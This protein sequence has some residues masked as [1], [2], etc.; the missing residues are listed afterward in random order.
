M[1]LN[2]HKFEKDIKTN[3]ARSYGLSVFALPQFIHAA[4]ANIMNL[5]LKL[6]KTTSLLIST[7]CLF[8]L[9]ISNKTGE[10]GMIVIILIPLIIIFFSIFFLASRKLKKE[11]IKG[12]E[13]LSPELIDY[14]YKYHQGF[15]NNIE[16]KAMN[17]YVTKMKFKNY[18]NNIP[19]EFKKLI[20]DDKKALG[21]LK[22]GY[23]R[24]VKN[25]AERIY[26]EHR[27]ELNLNLCPKC[28]KIA[29]TPQAKQCR[30]CS[31]DWH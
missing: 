14:I 28:N 9:I 12:T 20:T 19:P 5:T 18:E 27:K 3:A 26:K 29:R 24:F 22:K 31:Y 13:I 16:N 11:E 30:F 8:L 10:R 21:L 1:A 15:F 25:T 6:I 4:L 17:H 2:F 23:K 7:I